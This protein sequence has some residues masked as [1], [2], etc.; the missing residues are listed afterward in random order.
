L[1]EVFDDRIEIMSLLRGARDFERW[2]DGG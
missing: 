2:R 1:Y